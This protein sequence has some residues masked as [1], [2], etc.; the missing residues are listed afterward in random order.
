MK[1]VFVWLLLALAFVMPEMAWAAAGS[2]DPLGGNA[3]DLYVFGNGRIIF[4]VLNSVKMLMVPSAGSSGFQT[5]LVLMATLGFVVLAIAA[6]FDPGKNLIRMF[7]YILVVWGVSFGTTKLTANVNINDMVANRDGLRETYTVTGV[8]ALVA[9]PAALTS[10]VGWYFTTV[11]ETYFAMP[12][13]FK[14]AGSAAGQFNLFNKMI[15]ESNEFVLQNT[16]LKSSL[17]AYVADCVVPALAM[18]RLQGP[19]FNVA[20]NRMEMASGVDALHRSTNVMDTLSS[21]QHKSVMTKFFPSKATDPSWFSSASGGATVANAGG[22]GV[23]MTCEQAFTGLQHDVEMDANLLMDANAKAWS[24]AGIMTPYETAFQSMLAQAAA[25]GGVTYGRPSGFI[26]QQAMINSMSGSFRQAAVQTG[27]NELMQAAALAQAEQSQRSTWIAAFHVFNN[28]MGYVFTVLQAFIFAITPLVVVALMVPGL[29]RS[30][31]TNYAQILI[32]LTLWMPMLALINYIITLFGSEAIQSTLSMEGGLSPYNKGLLSER[33]NN[34]IIAAQFLGTMT[35]L[36]TWGLVKGSM[37][38]TEFISSG[39]GSAFASQAGAAAATGN[40]SMNNMSL[41]NTSMNKFNTAFSST[42]GSQAVN[43]FTNAGAALVAQDGGGGM[44]AMG[45]ATVDA[46]KAATD[47]LSR[48]ISQSE[49]VSKV[50]SDSL[51]NSTSLEQAYQKARSSGHGQSSERAAQ[52]IY[53]YAKSASLGQG[54]GKNMSVE[55]RENYGRQAAAMEKASRETR[56]NA[57]L[58]TPVVGANIARSGVLSNE[59][60]ESASK[61]NGKGTST[62][63]DQDRV[64]TGE[65]ASMAKSESTAIKST[66]DRRQDE[67]ASSRMASSYSRASSDIMNHQESMTRNLSATKSVVES[68]GYAQDM[69][70]GKVQNMMA[71]VDALQQTMPSEQEMNAKF[72]AM[73]SEFTGRQDATEAHYAAYKSQAEAKYT[74]LGPVSSGAPSVGAAAAFANLNTRANL[75]MGNHVDQVVRQNLDVGGK[76]ADIQKG[77]G[78]PNGENELTKNFRDPRGNNLGSSVDSVN[79]KNW[80]RPQ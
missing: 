49:A 36:L 16:S 69:D 17:S 68:F 9:L 6:G 62:A 66:S 18:N 65:A 24:N 55:E 3:W 76:V 75:V 59:D 1:T 5:L 33:T 51:S 8:P 77:A 53:Q 67:S 41:D 25:P 61:Q 74:A 7:G 52:Q 13:D 50:L 60:A 14:V 23:V 31:F 79:P 44:S 48:G 70:L 28:M 40:L 64:S 32:W 30:I 43:G 22:F 54:A 58:S 21:A 38:F 12:G 34:L 27:N 57:G 15:Q 29:G 46:K 2:V 56:V 4:D 19:V 71:Q 78:N 37:A 45:G 20:N 42:V 10:Q 73:S 72:A 47:A 39:V 35:P 26:M 63:L 80:I 11:I